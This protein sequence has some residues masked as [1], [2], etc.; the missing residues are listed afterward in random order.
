MVILSPAGHGCAF[1]P[2]HLCWGGFS[3]DCHL[4]SPQVAFSVFSF[5]MF[6][7]LTPHRNSH[8]LF[9]LPSLH[10]SAKSVDGQQQR[11]RQVL[12]K[13]HVFCFVRA[14]FHGPGL[15]Q[16]VT[17]LEAGRHLQ[18]GRAHNTFNACSHLISEQTPALCTACCR[19]A[20]PLQGAAAFMLFP[21]GFDCRDEL[22]C[23]SV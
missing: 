3:H 15:L 23:V 14:E 4:K 19:R 18:A 8:R 20:F 22:L 5:P 11:L 2:I 12:D 10:D 9:P 13:P 7:V 6:S 16:A 17:G 21:A 1:R